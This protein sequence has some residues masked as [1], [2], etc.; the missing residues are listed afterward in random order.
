MQQ[1]QSTSLITHPL[2]SQPLS[3]FPQ[4]QPHQHFVQKQIIKQ[5]RPH[6]HSSRKSL[7]IH[8]QNTEPASYTFRPSL[9]HANHIK[10]NKQIMNK[11]SLTNNATN[12]KFQGQIQRHNPH[13]N[14]M[15]KTVN[16][17]S[18]PKLTLQGPPV[19]RVISRQDVNN[20]QKYAIPQSKV[21]SNIEIV[22]SARISQ[23]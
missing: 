6:E 20:T 8:S 17:L 18:D 7:P 3:H 16:L 1:S 9:D 12:P 4:H 5:Q 22:E 14:Q 19:Y 23:I 2:T 13:H 21:Q 10:Y 11:L 15:T